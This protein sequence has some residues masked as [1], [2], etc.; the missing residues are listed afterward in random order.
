MALDFLYIQF[1]YAEFRNANG[2]LKFPH[3][4]AID[5]LGAVRIL[6]FADKISRGTPEDRVN[7]VLLVKA[8]TIALGGTVGAQLAFVSTLK[9]CPITRELYSG[10]EA[11][12]AHHKPH[13]RAYELPPIPGKK[14]DLS[15]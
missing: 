1:R 5:D 8:V 13:R 6:R 15:V 4:D 12:H 3:F 14:I 2:A 9:N 7:A 10:L 11:E